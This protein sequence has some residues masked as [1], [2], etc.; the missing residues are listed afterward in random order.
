MTEDQIAVLVRR[1]AGLPETARLRIIPLVEM[2]LRR[3]AKHVA[4]RQ[5]LRHWLLTNQATT[6]AALDAN[7][8]VDLSDIDL[9]HHVL[10]E[11]LRYGRIYHESSVYPLQWVSTP[12]QGALGGIF[13]TIFL[14]CWLEG[15]MLY[16]RSSDGNATPLTGNLSFAVPFWPALSA[17]PDALNELLVEKVLEELAE[18][19]QDYEE[20]EA[21]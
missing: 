5:N 15:T 10:I 9:T 13:D 6:T 2:G 19:H 18:H 4:E 11:C 14:H 16:T 8:V 3:L 12:S 20:A 21:A 1:R 7:G 17:L